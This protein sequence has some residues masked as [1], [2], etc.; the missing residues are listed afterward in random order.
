MKLDHWLI[1]HTK[2]NLK[3]IKGLNVK[4]ETIKIL[5][6][7]IGSKSLNI[8]LSNNFLNDTKSKNNKSKTQYETHSAQQ[9]NPL[10]KFK[11]KY[12]YIIH[13]IRGNCLKYIK[14]S[15][16]ALY[17]YKELYIYI[18][19]YIYRQTFIGMYNFNFMI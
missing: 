15:Y 17:I 10:T 4:P 11:R 13:M 2:I 5:E 9:R 6:E 12:L 3:C 7:N 18:Y 19:T 16:R 14:S 8:S 1:L